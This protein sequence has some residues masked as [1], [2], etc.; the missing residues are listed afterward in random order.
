MHAVLLRT[1]PWGGLLLALV[2]GIAFLGL[3]A[4]GR[5]EPLPAPP[6]PYNVRATLLPGQ[7]AARVQWDVDDDRQAIGYVV[8]RYDHGWP[9]EVA[10]PPQRGVDQEHEEWVPLSADEV[11]KGNLRFRVCVVGTAIAVCSNGVLA[12]RYMRPDDKALSQ[13][14]QNPGGAFTDLTKPTS[15]NPDAC[16][17][18]YVWRLARADDL[19][20]VTPPGRRRVARENAEGPSHADPDGAYGPQSCVSGY[21][22]RNALAGD[23]VCVTPDARDLAQR[24]NIEGKLSRAGTNDVRDNR[25][26][27]RIVQ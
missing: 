25:D 19:V 4:Q 21:V 24:E 3:A 6:P 13:V 23:L 26:E 17:N 16:V 22:W 10:Y 1:P 8:Q 5:A 15:A 12:S 20:C 9:S 7:S 14:T 11:A 27:R 18:G 2:A